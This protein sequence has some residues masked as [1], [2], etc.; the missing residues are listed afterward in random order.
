MSKR[1]RLTFGH[2]PINTVTIQVEYLCLINTTIKNAKKNLKKMD[3]IYNNLNLVDTKQL[4]GYDEIGPLLH[5]I[6]Y[7]SWFMFMDEII[8]I[9]KDLLNFFTDVNDTLQPTKIIKQINLLVKPISIPFFISLNHKLVKF[10]PPQVK[11]FVPNT[12]YNKF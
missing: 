2:D 10:K 3:K 4:D 8:H 1:H 5:I 7:E 12:I 11:L 9:Q 6:Y